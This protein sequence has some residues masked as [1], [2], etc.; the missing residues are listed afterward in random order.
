MSVAVKHFGDGIFG[1]LSPSASAKQQ[2]YLNFLNKYSQQNNFIILIPEDSKGSIEKKQES[3]LTSFMV[4]GPVFRAL[5]QSSFD[6]IGSQCFEYLKLALDTQEQV[7]IDIYQRSVVKNK[8]S[9]GGV[10][11][12]VPHKGSVKHLN[13]AVNSLKAQSY[14]TKVYV[15]L[16]EHVSESDLTKSQNIEYFKISPYDAGPYVIRDMLIQNCSSEFILFQDSDDYALEYRVRS[17]LSEAKKFNAD[18]VGSQEI[19]LNE[20]QKRV[21]AVRFPR[22]VNKALARGV[23]YPQLFPTTLIRRKSFEKMLGLCTN[24][25]YANDSKF[26]F[27]AHFFSKIIN[28]DEF[29]YIRRIRKNALTQN[30]QTDNMK[31]ERKRLAS[32][33]AVDF[34]NILSGVKSL[35]ATSLRSKKS[36]KK[37][38][39][40]KL[41][42]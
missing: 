9:P 21:T 31:A 22:D 20:I 35:K 8:L 30:G 29:L 36:S 1:H 26:L 34:D 16:D 15:G 23:R 4:T 32:L 42:I 12:I 19:Q 18:I 25:R 3:S 33:W 5:N 17:L 6:S 41:E 10:C 28:V 27:R 40:H 2:I 11:A 7:T 24:R 37:H 13:T 39:L 38:Q 14:S